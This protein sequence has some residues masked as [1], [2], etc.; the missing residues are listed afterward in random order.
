MSLRKKDGHADELEAGESAHANGAYKWL[1]G[2]L[3]S[4]G[5]I[6]AI[7]SACWKI[8]KCCS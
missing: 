6:A 5:T 4:L 8:W 2:G 7:A 3:I 1:I